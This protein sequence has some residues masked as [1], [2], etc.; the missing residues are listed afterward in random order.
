MRIVQNNMPLSTP[1]PL[2]ATVD[3]QATRAETNATIAA[4]PT[5]PASAVFFNGQT[6][7]KQRL[8]NMDDP[9]REAPLETVV[10]TMTRGQSRYNFLTLPDRAFIGKVYEYAQ[11]QGADLRYVNNLAFGLAGYRHD[12]NGRITGPHN[13]WPEQHK[14]GGETYHF[15]E[16][17]A[18]TAKRIREG[19]AFKTTELDKG[20]ILRVTDENYSS[21]YHPD[22]DFLERVINRFSDKGATEPLLGPAFTHYEPIRNN[23][24]KRGAQDARFPDSAGK[25]SGQPTEEAGKTGKKKLSSSPADL[26]QVLRE[27]LYRSIARIPS[28]FELLFKSKR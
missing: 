9:H 16:K 7:M 2:P 28:L 18:A 5:A 23:F 19:E 26:R 8:F 1:R 20:F 11:E 6:L 12:N 15:T 25:P 4:L 22:F 17:D 13:G 24:I 10:N 27:I 21:I 3:A 14:S